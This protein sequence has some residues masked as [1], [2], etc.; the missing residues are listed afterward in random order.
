MT[1]K[2]WVFNETV[3]TEMNGQSLKTLLSE[4]WGL[5]K[6]LVYSIR[7][8]ERVLIEGSYRPVNFAVTSGEHVQ[9]TFVPSDFAAPFPNVAPDSAATVEILYEDA[10]LVVI[11]KRRGDKTHPNQPG[12]VG[13]TIN[14]LAAY[15]KTENT[16]P[17]MIH[18]LDQETSGALI[19]AKNPAVVPILVANI[20][21]K[22]ITRKYLAWVE[23]TGLPEDGTIDQPIGRDPNDKR[24]RLINGTNAVN[25]V[26][27]FQVI[28]EEGGNSLL[29][30]ELETGRTHQIRVHFAAIGHPLVGD[31][32]YNSSNESDYLMLHSWKVGLILP[33]SKILKTVTAPIPSHFVDFQKQLESRHE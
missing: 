6:H 29:S 20:A 18:R 5:P 31:P 9:L 2:S 19:F 8:G 25:A 22:Q 30:I 7:H 27:H 24:K 10:N 11:N 3:P 17:Y 14:H 23:G 26:T 32:L 12:E 1:Q 33:F 13:A 4:Y 21:H 16:V 15:L 28:K